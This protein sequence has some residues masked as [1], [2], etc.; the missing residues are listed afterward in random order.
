MYAVSVL[1]QSMPYSPAK[2]NVSNSE[3]LKVLSGSKD[4]RCT[5]F[6]RG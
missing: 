3:R 4:P 2:G 1:S 6:E 5:A